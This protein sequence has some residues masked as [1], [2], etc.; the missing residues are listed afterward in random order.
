MRRVLT[1]QVLVNALGIND[2][3]GSPPPPTVEVWADVY[4]NFTR[5][6]RRLLWQPAWQLL[7]ILSLLARHCLVCKQS[8]CHAQIMY[9]L[10]G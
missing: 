2:F 10:H 4:A 9:D 6:V 7:T 5:G 1:V 8:D 3:H